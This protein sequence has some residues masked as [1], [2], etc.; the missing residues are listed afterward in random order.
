MDHIISRS[1]LEARRLLNEQQ[2]AMTIPVNVVE[3]AQKLGAAVHYDELENEVSGMLVIN[4]DE[5]HIVVNKLHPANRQRFTIAHE[6]GHLVLHAVN[7]A[8]SLFVDTKYLV[9]RRAGSANSA[10]Y[11]QPHS[12]T[13]P[14]EEREANEFSAA[15]LMPEALVRFYVEDRKIDIRDEFDIAMIATAFGVS[16]QAMSIR[17]RKLK[18]LE[19]V[20]E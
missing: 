6:L 10:E 14:E 18:L 19:V 11:F 3:I 13:T 9:Y 16:E 17:A 8:R 7:S 4:G 20:D 1:E 15:L 5:K 2:Q 12:T